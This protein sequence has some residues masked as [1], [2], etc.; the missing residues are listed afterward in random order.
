MLNNV[1]YEIEARL[2]LDADW[3]EN[4]FIMDITAMP[5]PLPVLAAGESQNVAIEATIPQ[6]APIGAY[7]L[8]VQVD[9]ESDD[10][11]YGKVREVEEANNF[12]AFS[13]ALI[14]IDM[15]IE[16]ALD[17]DPIGIYGYTLPCGISSR[18]IGSDCADR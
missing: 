9:P 4:D 11:P 13:A 12:G 6:N 1:D 17:M 8:L 3:D 14:T 7:Y 10:F 16:E 15:T 2:S 5:E 18:C